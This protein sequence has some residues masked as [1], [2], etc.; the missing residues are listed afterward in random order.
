MARTVEVVNGK[1]RYEGR[2]LEEWV[3]EIVTELVAAVDPLEIVLFGSVARRE[4]QVRYARP[5]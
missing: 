3:P 5:A 1:A 4:G 2:T